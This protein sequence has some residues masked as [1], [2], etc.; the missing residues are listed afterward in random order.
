[1]EWLKR[2]IYIYSFGLFFLI[3]RS[4]QYFQSFQPFVFFCFFFFYCLIN[5]VAVT[6]Q[7]KA[8]LYKY[9]VSWLLLGWIFS[10]FIV[11]VSYFLIGNLNSFFFEFRHLLL[12]LAILIVILLFSFFIHRIGRNINSQ[13]IFIL[14]QFLNVFIFIL[15]GSV[16]LDGIRNYQREDKRK[17]ASEDRKIAQLDVKRKR[18]I[19]WILLDE[20]TS[21]SSLRSQFQFHDPLVDSL[22]KNGF[23]VFDALHSRSDVTIYSVNS[24]FNMDD[25]IPVPNFLYAAAYLNNNTLVKQLT[26]NNY[27]FVNLDFFNI[28]NHPKFLNLLIFPDNYVDQLLFGSVFDLL[29]D[30][31]SKGKVSFDEYNQHVIKEFQK[32]T[33]KKRNRPSFI[34]THLLIPH[35][36]FVRDAKGALN[37]SA[38]SDTRTGSRSEVIDQYTAYLTYGNGVVLH[39][40]NEIPDWRNKIIVISGDHGARMFI[41]DKDSRRKE[42]FGAIYYPGMDTKELSTIK[43]M[44]QIPYHLH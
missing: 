28:G 38:L 10:L 43:Y 12:F 42:T 31:F 27:E 6:I 7:K 11:P 37:K 14:N 5:Y 33:H 4:A 15:T 21:P 35:L 1:M 16:I 23:F 13:K 41:P 8:G 24:L 26:R 34:W 17:I 36:P 22:R 3:Y 20:Y 19:I 2:P 18:D 30:G 9:G 40:L 25:S 32:E 39:I 29:L 44:Q